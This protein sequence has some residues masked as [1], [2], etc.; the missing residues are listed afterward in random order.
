[1][2]CCLSY[3]NPRFPT[4]AASAAA[5]LRRPITFGL[6]VGRRPPLIVVASANSASKCEFGGL[7]AP[8]EPRTPV[9]R[10]LKGVLLD[11]RASFHD[12]ARKELERLAAE[13]EEAVARLQL[14]LGS[15]EACL[16]RL[17]T[18]LFPFFLSFYFNNVY[19]NL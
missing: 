11:D 6:R 13:R 14:S 16:H 1:M 15:D 18:A 3:T 12:S 5:S 19:A 10:L 2:D 17:V 9:G 7:N 8:L 4:P